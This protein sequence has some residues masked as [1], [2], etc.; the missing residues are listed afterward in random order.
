MTKFKVII[1]DYEYANIDHE[2]RI[3]SKIG[4]QIFP[5]QTKDEN[6]IIAAAHDCDAL[7]VQ[8]AKITSKVIDQLHK[9]KIIAKYATSIETIDIEAASKNGICVTNVPDYCTD[10]VSTHAAAMLLNLSRKINSYSTAIS[11]GKWDYKIGSPIANLKKSI[12]GVIG[13]GKISSAFI[14]KLRPFCDEIWVY[15]SSASEDSVN[16][17]GAKL[18]S[19]DAIV[20]EADYISIFS[21]LTNATRNLFNK[22]VFKAMKNTAFMINISR[23][24][25]VNE[26][27]LIWALK[28]N[29]LAGAALDVMEFEPPLETNA[30]LTMD[31]V[32]ITPH[33][34]WY[35]TD[36]QHKLQTSVAADVAK[37]L[38]GYLPDNLVNP[39]VNQILKLI[40][41]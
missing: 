11:N 1:T 34:A 4:A 20:K 32:I 13:F 31:N 19:F 37:V 26:D 7:I 39:Q 25:L 29:K 10:E 30:L 2:K 27:D 12:I 28:N 35:S 22:D 38:S 36:S 23:G 15:S 33:A 9:C 17:L 16:Q 41:Y 18:K 24:G 21:P 6:E 5:Y 40:T 3:L 8:Y 14:Q